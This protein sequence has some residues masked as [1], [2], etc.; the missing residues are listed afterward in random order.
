MGTINLAEL[1]VEFK[2]D[3]NID[4]P[5]MMSVLEDVF[6]IALARQF[7]TSDNFAVIINADKGDLE[8][9]K[10]RIVVA[11]DEFEDAVTQIP[12]S[13]AQKIDEDYE[14]GE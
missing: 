8:I 12:L 13:E 14:I 10:N 1:F 9:W 4:R 3:K 2:D 5:T 6:R 7:G 11:D